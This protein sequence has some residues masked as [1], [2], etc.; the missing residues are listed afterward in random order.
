MWFLF[1]VTKPKCG[2]GGK[3]C[4]FWVVPGLC[5]TCVLHITRISINVEIMSSAMTKI[6][7]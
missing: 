4:S 7:R 3:C 1:N 6:K 5:L 2:V